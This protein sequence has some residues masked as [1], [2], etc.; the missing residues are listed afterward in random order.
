VEERKDGVPDRRGVG[1][2]VKKMGWVK[3]KVTSQERPTTSRRAV[4][5]SRAWT[6][7]PERGMYPWL[8]RV[9]SIGQGPRMSDAVGGAKV[10][11]GRVSGCECGLSIAIGT[12]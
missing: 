9:L 11:R 1:L 10:P 3:R 12:R 8:A 6:L 2:G 5:M 4:V 7:R